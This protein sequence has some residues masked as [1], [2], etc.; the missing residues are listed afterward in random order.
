[1]DTVKQSWH[2]IVA[3]CRQEV[4][5]RRAFVHYSMRT[6]RHFSGEGAE[7]CGSASHPVPYVRD[8]YRSIKTRVQFNFKLPVEKL[9]NIK[10]LYREEEELS[11]IP[12]KIKNCKIHKLIAH[13][14]LL[15][16]AFFQATILTTIIHFGYAPFL[17]FL[18]TLLAQDTCR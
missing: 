9:R 10:V 8:V 18:D 6:G 12:N 1:M 17:S 14:S 4:E 2:F 16:I 13:C 15:N 7:C 11:N 5:N 3:L